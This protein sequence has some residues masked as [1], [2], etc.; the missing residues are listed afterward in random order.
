MKV[1][2][3]REDGYH[4]IFSLVDKIALYDIITVEEAEE[5][6]V[7][8]PSV[9]GEENTVTKALRLFRERTGIEKKFC[10][11][12]S[13]KIPI[14]GGLGGG[15]SDAA[16]VIK[17]LNSISEKRLGDKELMELASEIGSDVP[18]FL[19]DG[20]CFISGRGEK[21]YPVKMDFKRWYVILKPPFGL[22]S[23]EVYE[24]F[25]RNPE[26]GYLNDLEKPAIRLKP[27]LKALKKFLYEE[28]NP[29]ISS[30]SGSGSSL[31]S[32]FLTKDGASSFAESLKKKKELKG[33]EIYLVEG[34][35]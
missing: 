28:G 6:I 4:E 8:I 29:V 13:K 17:I 24:E 27:E 23:K 19:I 16:C 35:G 5:D 7:T 3:K 14:S 20:P 12:V 21:V 22:S 33:C 11:T 32:L 26:T 31:F 10:I 2:K 9:Y 18:L 1:L 34:I 15:S 30:I 25:D